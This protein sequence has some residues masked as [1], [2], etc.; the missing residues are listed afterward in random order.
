[1]VGAGGIWRARKPGHSAITRNFLRH[2]NRAAVKAL[3]GD[4]KLEEEVARCRGETD[5]STPGC[6]LTGMS[7]FLSGRG[8]APVGEATG[9]EMIAN[10][11]RIKEEELT[12][13]AG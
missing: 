1:L 6:W 9:I 4:L 7:S 5:D 12:A 3:C 11:D 13:S 10:L 8:R 2:S